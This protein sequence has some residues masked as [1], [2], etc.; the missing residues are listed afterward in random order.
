MRRVIETIED[1]TADERANA[2]AVA[3]CYQELALY[4]RA[5][6]ERLVQVQRAVQAAYAP[7]GPTNYDLLALIGWVM[8]QLRAAG[9][10]TD[11]TLDL[12]TYQALQLDR[13][14]AVQPPPENPA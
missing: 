3:Y 10:P 4:G 9:L 2:T 11:F 5:N 1:I 13:V 8:Y 7:T 14:E 6:N 12:L